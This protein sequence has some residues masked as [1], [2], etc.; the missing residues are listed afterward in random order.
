M[1]KHPE[2]ALKVKNLDT[3]IDF[4]V[5]RVGFT[6]QD[7]L[8]AHDL[9][10]VHDLD[11]DFILLAGPKVENVKEHLEGVAFVIQP[12]E[13]IRFAEE[14]LDARQA[15]LLEHG[16]SDL[17]F[18]ETATGDRV[19]S[20]QGPDN[21]TVAFVAAVQ[22]SYDEWLRMYELGPS[23]LQVALEGLSEA[24]LDLSR[25]PGQWSIRQIVHHLADGELLWTPV[26]KSALA[27]SGST[28]IRNLYNQETWPE[29]F[30]N[31]TRPVNS[32]VALITALRIHLVELSR[33]VPNNEEQFVMMRTID[34]DPEG[35][36]GTVKELVSGMV[37]H[38]EEHCEEIRAIRKVHGR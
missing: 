12:G 23:N 27:Q 10:Y 21:Y 29:I 26:I 38:M 8:P 17:R 20:V 35:H 28:Y 5:N 31:A 14:N 9:A 34:G 33:S 7:H 15:T 6:L 18:E 32:S 19:L 25:T 13:T 3:G 11:G 37:H 1:E 24:D 36:K 22:R 2:V 4:F 30:K 16:L